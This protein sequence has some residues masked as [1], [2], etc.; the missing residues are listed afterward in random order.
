MNST[1]MS[2]RKVLDPCYLE[3][4]QCTLKLYLVRRWTKCWV[5]DLH[6][7]VIVPMM[8]PAFIIGCELVS[9]TTLCSYVTWISEAFRVVQ[10]RQHRPVGSLLTA[11]QCQD[12]EM[13]SSRFF[14]RFLSS[15]P[16][17]K[18]QL[19]FIHFFKEIKSF[20]LAE[21]PTTP[22]PGNSNPFCGVRYIFS[23]TAQF[24]SL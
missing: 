16:L 15:L 4:E 11:N 18:F 8:L 21:S 3:S 7:I 22:T 1:K 20:V 14:L 13:C 12:I 6:E 5:K 19:S 9:L 23:G 17:W 24:Y 2:L 10:S